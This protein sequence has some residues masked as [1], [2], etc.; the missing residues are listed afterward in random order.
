MGE[1]NIYCKPTFMNIPEEKREKILSVAYA[2]ENKSEHPIAKAITN[3]AKERDIKLLDTSNF[4]TFAGRGVSAELEFGGEIG[5][6]YIGNLPF[7]CEHISVSSKLQNVVSDYAKNGKT[8]MVLAFAGEIVGVIA[9]ADILKFDSAS[10][11][12]ELNK[13]GV[14]TVMLTGDNEQTANAIAS[15]IGIGEVI[16][17]VLPNQKL[18]EI[19]R[20]QKDGSTVIMVGDG[21][22]DSPA[23]VGA[24]VGIAIGAGTDVAIDSA[25]VVLIKNEISDVAK[26][27]KIGRRTL[28]CIKEN[29]FWAFFYNVCGIPIAAGVFAGLGL[30]LN[31]MIG[32]A[33]MSLSSFTVVMNALRL[34]YLRI[35]KKNA[36]KNTEKTNFEEKALKTMETV[37]YI[38]GMMC[39]HCEGRVKKCLEAI[40]GVNEAIVSHEKGEALIKYG[41]EIPFETFKNAVEAQ[42]YDVK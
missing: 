24:D 9:V 36:P 40:D 21:I 7:V 4:N 11:I 8:P 37:M 25:D 22:N 15:Q 35:E 26:A 3:Y 1:N 31:P 42:G 33:A 6:A 17:G 5:V 14:K 41:V 27:M 12:S 32:A 28:T 29:L 13:M 20:L 2:L 30:V 19:E 38:D 34:N 16:A 18:A 10:A 23:L 39:P